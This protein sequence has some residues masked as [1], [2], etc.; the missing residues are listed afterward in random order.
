MTTVTDKIRD[1]LNT[2]GAVLWVL[3]VVFCWIDSPPSRYIGFLVVTLL[4]IIYFVLG[5]T[6]EGRV[7]L[8]YPILAMAVVRV[9]AFTI[10]YLT[11]GRATDTWI[12][13]LHPGQ[14]WAV[15]LFWIGT[16]LTSMLGYAL[17]FDRYILPDEKWESFLKEVEQVKINKDD[18]GGYKS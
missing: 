9:I 14:F 7:P 17:Y 13:G 11:R 5:I 12:L 10:A 16:F 15:I 2:I 8:I 6:V 18:K 4:G 3:L 1:I